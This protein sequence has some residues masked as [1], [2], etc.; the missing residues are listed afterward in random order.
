MNYEDFISSRTEMTVTQYLN[1]YLSP[2]DRENF[3]KDCIKVHVYVD[4]MYIE[5]L[6]NKVFY[7]L[8]DRTDCEGT[9][10]TCEITLWE[11]FAEDELKDRYNR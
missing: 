9:L 2:S 1:T 10:H 3:H 5:E 4:G 11:N 6:P 7:V 8:Y